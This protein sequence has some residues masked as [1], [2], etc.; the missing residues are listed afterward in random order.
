[1][2]GNLYIRIGRQ[3]KRA[4]EKLG[5]SQEELAQRL[6]YT[7]PATISHF[8]T[9]Q[10]KISIADL[11]RLSDILGPPPEYFFETNEK[12]KGMQHYR[13]RATEVKPSARDTVAGFLAFAST[14][15][16]KS[17]QVS[18]ELIGLRPGSAADKILEITKIKEPPISPSQISKDLNIPVFYWDFPDEVS[19]I[20]VSEENA[21]C[22]GVNQD[23]SYVRQKFTIA[24]ELGH[25]VYHNG[26][27][28]CVDFIDTEM[29]TPDLD[30]Q[31]RS[32][33]TKANQF[34]ASLL[35]PMEWIKGDFHKHGVEALPLL[36]QRYE[37]SEQSL[38]YRLHSL[39]L[40]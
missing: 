19:G 6:G 22:I 15:R 13:L 11:Q 10:R 17:L 12:T 40:V 1:M 29:T 5:I 4:R 2:A 37:V 36:S 9:G 7:S 34:A 23:H 3:I 30:E 18:D 31:Q 21:T 24:H 33:E 39:K 20:F 25:F 35:M 26:D 28:L 16:Q 38:W 32:E 14:H 27:E 8:E